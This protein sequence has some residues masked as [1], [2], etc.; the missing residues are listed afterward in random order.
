VRNF[1][2]VIIE[3]LKHQSEK[4]H[5]LEKTINII[6]KFDSIATNLFKDE[7]VKEALLKAILKQGTGKGLIEAGNH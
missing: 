7:N 1:L 2:Y 5:A 6:N 4:I 3:D